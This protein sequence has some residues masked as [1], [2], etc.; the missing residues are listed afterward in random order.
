M[1][2]TTNWDLK[3]SHRNSDMLK[4][5]LKQNRLNVELSFFLVQPPCINKPIP[6]D[7]FRGMMLGLAIGDALGNTSESLLPATR[8]K[9]HGEIRDYLGNR[10]ANNQP[11]GLPSDDTQMAFWTLESIIE[12][13]GVIPTELAE[14]F[15]TRPI[16]GRGQSVG[17]FVAKYQQ[18]HEWPEASSMSAGNGALMRIPAVL[19]PHINGPTEEL[20][21]DTVLCAAVTHN[22]PAS[23]SSCVAFAGMLNE[24]SQMTTAPD[25]LWWV[26][27]YVFYAH[28]LEGDCKYS[29]RG[30]EYVGKFSGTLSEFVQF[31]VP[32]A[33]DAGMSTLEACNEWFSG[34]YLL[35]T[36]P[37]V[38]FIL[39][40][41][42]HDPEE[43]IVRAVNDTKDNDTI[44]AIVGAAVG[45]LHG[46]N[47]LPIRWI[48]NL[49]GRTTYDDDG[50]VFELLDAFTIQESEKPMP[51][52]EFLEGK[53][54]DTN[55]RMIDD[56]IGFDDTNI[57]NTHD[58][59]QWTFPL[60]EA[61]QA[62][63]NSPVLS[64]QEVDQI[65]LSSI[66][67]ENL[68]RCS[69][70][71][72]GFLERN[73]HW[74]TWHNHNHLRISRAIKSLRLL[75]GNETADNFKS[76]VLTFVDEDLP[77]ISQKSVSFWKSS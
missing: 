57:E 41:H 61:S 34:A 39:A 6:T 31:V 42:A 72:L 16:F 44:A 40:N 37:S 75:S 60:K 35:E 77:K 46:E 23:I 38:L 73:R 20:W 63:F 58:F 76:A 7:R 32:D 25:R 64:D 49:L 43:A 51:L 48:E 33:L 5:L 2:A 27:R 8:N 55:G 66:A 68:L 3:M 74:I 19:A 13:G 28:H 18:G 71:F 22:D 45:A 52:R 15:A 9:L 14:K 11:V 56:V 30:G 21:A 59:I 69:K 67:Q 17:E 47:A 54:T 4:F 10:Y 26:E 1:V 50:R 70:W 29:P 53:G 12:T 65:R 36:V 24:L 62:V